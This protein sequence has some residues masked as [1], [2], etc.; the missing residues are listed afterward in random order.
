MD[1][2]ADHKKSI[3]VLLAVFFLFAAQLKPLHYL[4]ARHSITITKNRDLC[5]IQHAQGHCAVCDY[6][7]SFAIAAAPQAANIIVQHYVLLKTIR[8]PYHIP[9]VIFDSFKRGPP[10]FRCNTVL[11]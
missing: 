2:A 5:S 6:H 11:S 3:T 9:T 10:F 8:F 4:V 7:F 1:R